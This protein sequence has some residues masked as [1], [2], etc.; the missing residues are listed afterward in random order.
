MEG[1]VMTYDVDSTTQS[2]NLRRQQEYAGRWGVS[3][4]E[5]MMPKAEMF[6]GDWYLDEFCN[7]TREIK[8]RD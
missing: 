6:V 5:Q 4:Y 3:Y 7:Q 2:N 1:D 8:A